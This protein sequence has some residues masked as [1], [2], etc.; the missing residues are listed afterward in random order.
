MKT[1][2]F[3]IAMFSF[4]LVMAQTTFMYTE[5]SPLSYGYVCEENSLIFTNTIETIIKGS[6]YAAD[7]VE[8]IPLH[9]FGMTILPADPCVGC[10]EPTSG[11]TLGT[12]KGGNGG[13][14]KAKKIA[15]K[16]TIKQQQLTIEENPVHHILQFSLEA[17]A[18]K[19][20]IISDAG[21]RQM[22]THKGNGKTKD[23]LNVTKLIKGV[24]WLSVITTDNKIYTKQFIKQ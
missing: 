11:S 3:F 12:K 5:T 18:I 19:T 14:H 13:I 7:E 2:F 23:E 17:G 22:I 20:I 16:E 4:P 10:T 1:N 6:I 15:P 8:V 9:G 24:Y 21:G